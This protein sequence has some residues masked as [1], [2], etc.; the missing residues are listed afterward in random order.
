MVDDRLV[1]LQ[2]V[3]DQSEVIILGVPHKAYRGLAFGAERDVVDIW[4]A[5]GDGIRL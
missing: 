2:E 1:P 5:L 3:V 4:G